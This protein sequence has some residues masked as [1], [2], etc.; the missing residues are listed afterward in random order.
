MNEVSEGAVTLYRG[1]FL[2]GGSL[3]SGSFPDV[4]VEQPLETAQGRAEIIPGDE[5]R[6]RRTESDGGISR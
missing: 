4:S 2:T 6:T 5:N 3:I 1:R